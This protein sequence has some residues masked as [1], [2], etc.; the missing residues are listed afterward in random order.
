LILALRR[1]YPET[2]GRSTR[3]PRPEWY[4]AYRWSWE[5]RVAEFLFIAGLVSMGREPLQADL[6]T[7]RLLIGGGLVVFSYLLDSGAALERRQA[8]LERELAA[9]RDAVDKRREI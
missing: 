9:L 5:R 8:W 7:R 3:E 2:P 4:Q 1:Y 6:H